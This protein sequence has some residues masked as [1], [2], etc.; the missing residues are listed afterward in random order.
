M[1]W[2]AIGAV[3]EL[4][5]AI[6]VIISLIYLAGQI[7][8]NTRAQ[9]RT[10][11]GDIAKELA[12][13]ARSTALS[14]ELSSLVLRGHADLESLNPVERYQYDTFIYAFIANF[15]RALIDARDGDYPEEQLV[16]MRA[17]IAG[18]LDTDGG[19]VWWEQRRT[20]FTAFGQQSINAIL[21]DQMI[22]SHGAGPVAIT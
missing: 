12:T 19:R 10:N 4:L 13:S 21:S 9:K 17:A 1:N 8:R 15:E 6:G 18:Y 11:L 16:P 14:A 22:D 3:A 5:G 2:D 20:W 7:R